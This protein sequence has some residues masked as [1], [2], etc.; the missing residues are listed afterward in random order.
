MTQ[1]QRAYLVN[2]GQSILTYPPVGVAFMAGVC[3]RAGVEYKTLDLNLEFLQYTDQATWDQVFLHI[4]LGRTMPDLPTP[5]LLQ[6]DNFLDHVVERICAYEP[7]CVATTLLTYV[8][9]YWA[10]RFW[11]RLRPRFSGTIIAGGSGVSVPGVTEKTSALTFGEDM[12]RKG[13]L[14]YYVLGEGDLILEQ[15][16]QGN[17]DL[18]GLNHAKSHNSWQPQLDDLDLFATPSYKKISFDGYHPVE[19][20]QDPDDKKYLISVTG[21][22][23]CVRRCSFCDI[24]HLWKKFRYR[25]GS[26][27]ADEI[28]KHHLDTGSTDFWFTDSL[29]N[30]SLKQF[31][32]L[33][34]QLVKHRQNVESLR[35]L[36]YNGQFII[37]PRS[38]HPERLFQQLKESGCN[39]L[40]IGI[41]SGSESVR[42]HMGKKFSNA[43]I[44]WHF[45][46]CEKYQIK[47]WILLITGYPTETEQDHQDT[48]DMLIRNQKYIVNHTILGI[49]LQ[50]VMSLLPNSPIANMSELG[51][52]FH[53]SAPGGTYG[54]YSNWM[55]DAN[56]TLTQARRYQRFAEL[57]ET[58]VQLRYNLPTEIMYFLQQ[59]SVGPDGELQV[60]I[61]SES[62]ILN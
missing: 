42:D 48:L 56:P 36:R 6:V 17:R 54:S 51:L 1:I 59:H 19:G 62:S 40:S 37:R 22:R 55:S 39:R 4:T 29:I 12:V 3:E 15:F 31:N 60:P 41:E 26:N 27:I 32:D 20:R 53:D 14:D 34:T 52:H 43:D 33:M 11:Q 45:E 7:D 16:F 30:G 13:L 21:S 8:Q 44:D 58:S 35:D 2:S 61:I 10:E 50:H 23:G 28:L 57:A 49:N 25:S 46:M 5:V 9:Q 47:N 24:G 18:L 38:D